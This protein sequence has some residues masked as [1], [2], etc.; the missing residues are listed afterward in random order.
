M[1]I[2]LAV[3][4]GLVLLYVGLAFAK[5][6]TEALA[7]VFGAVDREPV[8]F[9]TLQLK[10]TPNQFL[11]APQGLCRNAKPHLEA[12]V[13][14]IPV[15]ALRE[16]WM[17]RI[18]QQ[19]RVT[20]LTADPRREQY[21]FEQRSALVGFPDTITVRFL[22]AGEGRSTL[23]IYSRSHYGKADFGVNEKRIRAWLALLS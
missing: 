23:A 20:E 18:P 13:F 6:K 17:Q 7:M 5:G 2:V 14:D 9:E 3:V 8:D 4:G 21:D 1:G 12:P 16:R 10:S 22:P 15:V 11:V 19:P